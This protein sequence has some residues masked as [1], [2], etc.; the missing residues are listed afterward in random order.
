MAASSVRAK[1]GARPKAG[2]PQMPKAYG[3]KGPRSGSGLMP[4]S[5]ASAQL[6]KSR[7]Y[8]VCTV[9]ADGRPHAMP[10]WGVW[11]DGKLYFGTSRS[12]Q[13]G[14]NLERD[15]RVVVHLES[16]DEALILEGVVEEVTERERYA[17]YADVYDAKY[18][19]RPEPHS[20]DD[21]TYAVRP[22]TAFGWL[23]KDY[24]GSAT[25]WKF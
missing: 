24:T 22:L 23:E 18:Q 10:V 13:K 17:V 1:Q 2:R 14:R 16:G 7:N 3:L 20:R 4:W 6:A 9:R 12:S 8:W 19:F 5:W 25:R 11:L 21:V 15:S